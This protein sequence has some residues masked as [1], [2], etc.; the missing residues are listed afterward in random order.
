M[1]VIFAFLA[2]L[3]LVAAFA[4]QQGARPSTQLNEKFWDKVFSMDL[5]TPVADQNNYGA[6][7]KM[8]KIKKGKVGSGSYVPAGLTLAEYQKIRE[9][10]DAKAKANYEKNVNKAFK[11]QSFDSFYNKRGTAE[12]GAW[13]KAPG[14]GHTFAKTKYDF[15]GSK[16]ETKGWKDAVGDIFG[17]K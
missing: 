6:R 4:P 17:K 11:F 15:S 14:R 5:F 10:D 13:M 1:K 12:N 16:D 3:S 2:V 7:N 9:A 8:Q